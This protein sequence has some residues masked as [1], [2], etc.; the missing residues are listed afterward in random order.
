MNDPLSLSNGGLTHIAR[1]RRRELRNL[2]RKLQTAEIK[3]RQLRGEFDR[4]FY[5]WHEDGSS[6]T[7]LALA[8]GVSRE[9]VYRSIE[10]YRTELAA[11]KKK[12]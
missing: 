2:S 1:E 9:T 8:A 11:M 10:R 4:L 3:V 5:V 7:E 12:G 6:I